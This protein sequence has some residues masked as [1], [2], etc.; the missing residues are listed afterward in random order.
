MYMYVI[1]NYVSSLSAKHNLSCVYSKEPYQGDDSI[2]QPKHTFKLIDKKNYRI[3]S[4]MLKYFAFYWIYGISSK[5][6]NA[7]CLPKSADPDQTA[8]EEAV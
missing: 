5:I 7:S 3:K 2:E 4:I 8:S 6:W 1:E